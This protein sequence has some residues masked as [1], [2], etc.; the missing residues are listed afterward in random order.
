MKFLAKHKVLLISL[1]VA[2]AILGFGKLP[3]LSADYGHDQAGYMYMGRAISQ[4]ELPFRDMWDHKNPGLAYI[5]SVVY[6]LGGHTLETFRLFELFWMVLTL[7]AFV[8]LLRKLFKGEHLL[9]QGL[10]VVYFALIM[11]E[12]SFSTAD[13]GGYTE[14]FM[15]LPALGAL[16]LLVHYEQH[17]RWFVPA[18][19]GL[20]IFCSFWIKQSGVVLAL[21]ALVFLAA[22]WMKEKKGWSSFLWLALGFFLPLGLMLVY[23]HFTG[24]FSSY[25]D[26]TIVFNQLYSGGD[27]WFDK[28]VGSIYILHQQALVHPITYLL[29]AFG[30]VA[31]LARRHKY[32]CLVGVWFAADLIGVGITGKFFAHYYIQ[33]FPALA[34]LTAF[35]LITLAQA[36]PT[37]FKQH[38]TAFTLALFPFFLL[39]FIPFIS[40]PT[41]N[42]ILKWNDLRKHAH[43]YSVSNDSRELMA[44]V[45][46]HTQPGDTIYIWDSSQIRVYLETGTYS[47]SRYFHGIPFSSKHAPGYA[48]GNRWLELKNDLQ[49][50]PPKVILVDEVTIQGLTTNKTVW[51]YVSTHYHLD[52]RIEDVHGP[53]DLYLPN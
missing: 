14:T 32:T 29:A 9:G 16:I 45:E 6:F 49:N 25:I 13:G 53:T 2:L 30:A 51:D 26:N 7:A 34:I 24:T 5:N 3:F 50:N 17:R 36:V 23:F 42:Y 8:V 35:G 43:T 33:L 10:G 37:Y 38:S 12:I 52:K 1:A 28:F 46:D 22:V 11:T 44:Y 47:S 18:L 48:G 19:V 39:V 20:L 41:M 27:T 4:G 31:L 15:L 21:P 40:T